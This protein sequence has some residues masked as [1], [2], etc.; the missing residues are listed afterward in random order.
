MKCIICEKE[1]KESKYRHKIL[2]SDECFH[3]DFWNDTLDDKAIIIDG[4]CYHDEGKK[5]DNYTGILGHSGRIFEIQMNDGTYI[6]T[7]NLWCNGA[8][9]EDRCVKDNAHFVNK[10]KGEF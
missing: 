8:I 10:I 3:I 6:Q 5:P 9:P 2:C 4:V 1:I 7:N